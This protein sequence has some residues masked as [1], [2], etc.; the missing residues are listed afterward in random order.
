MPGMR[1]TSATLTLRL[2]TP[3]GTH[4]IDVQ[5]RRVEDKQPVNFALDRKG[6]STSNISRSAEAPKPAQTSN[7]LSIIVA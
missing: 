6:N 5:P 7:T 2:A 1:F 4:F 3:E